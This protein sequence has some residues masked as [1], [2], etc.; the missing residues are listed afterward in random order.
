MNRNR[1]EQDLNFIENHYSL[2]G[3]DLKNKH[4]VSCIRQGADK[5]VDE[6]TA[7]SREFVCSPDLTKQEWHGQIGMDGSGY[8]QGIFC[9]GN[10]KAGMHE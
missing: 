6:T 2:T 3:G 1:Q 5:G 10:Q 7:E 8:L 9:K 4:K